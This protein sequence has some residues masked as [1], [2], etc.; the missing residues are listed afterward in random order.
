LVLIVLGLIV[1]ASTM[2]T[3]APLEIRLCGRY[4]N[5]AYD[6]T[7][8]NSGNCTA[9]PVNGN[10]DLDN[11]GEC[12][13][14]VSWFSTSDWIQFNNVSAPAGTYSLSVRTSGHQDRTPTITVNIDGTDYVVTGL[15]K[16]GY[17]NYG[18]TNYGN[19]MLSGA[20]HTVRVSTATG[21][22]NLDWVK[23]TGVSTSAPSVPTN[24]EA[25][26][27]STSSIKV[28]W[29][30]ST[31]GAAVVGYKVYQDGNEAATYTL[32]TSHQTVIGPFSPTAGSWNAVANGGFESTITNP[33]WY[34]SWSTPGAHVQSNEQKARGSY[35]NKT[36]Q[37]SPAIGWSVLHQDLSLTAGAKY[38]LSS[39]FYVISGATGDGF[40]DMSDN[41]TPAANMNVTGVWQF[42]Y[43]QFTA[44][45]SNTVRVARGQSTWTGSVYFDEVAVTP[46]G[47]FVHPFPLTRN[48]TG[49]SA[50]MKY[51]LTVR[52]Y[53]E[54][55]NYSSHSSAVNRYT[56][57]EPAA[58]PTFSDVTDVGIIV[59][60][61][62]PVNLTADSS[63]VIFNRSGSDLDKVQFL[64]ASDS[65]L[66]PNTQYAYKAKAVNGDGIETAY[67]SIASKYTLAAAP[68]EGNNVCC[69]KTSGTWYA[70]GS[71]FT[72]NNPAGFGTGSHGG[73][74]YKVSKFKYAW[75]MSQN[76]TW[77]GSEA[78]WNSGNLQ[79]SADQGEG[80]YYLHLK[81][82]NAEDAENPT[83][84]DYGP[85]NSA[86]TAVGENKKKVD[87]A[88]VFLIGKT[89]TAIFDD[90]FYIEEMDRS[91][92]IRIVASET[93]E[94]LAVGD[95]VDVEGII[96]TNTADERYVEATSITS[97]SG[98]PL[99]PVGM[100]TREVGGSDW[101]YDPNTGAGQKGVENNEGNLNNIGKLVRVTGNVTAVGSDFFYLLDGY[102]ARDYSVFSGIRVRCESE[103]TKPASGTLRLCGY[104]HQPDNEGQRP[105]VQERSGT[106]QQLG[107]THR[108]SGI[109]GL[110]N[111]MDKASPIPETTGQIY[112]KQGSL[113]LVNREEKGMRNG[114]LL[115]S[116]L[117]ITILMQATAA[118][119]V[120]VP[121]YGIY[122]VTLTASGSYTNPYLMMPAD[123]TTPGFVV[124]T[125][126]GPGG[127]QIKVD[128][129]WDGGSTWKLRIMPTVVGDW[130]YT[131]SSSDAGL[132]AKSGSFTCVAS[133]SKGYPKVD[134]ARSHHYMWSDGSPFYFAGVCTI[135]SNFDYDFGRT[136]QGGTRRVDNGEFQ[137]FMD[138]RKSQRFTYGGGCIAFQQAAVESENPGERRRRSIH[139][140]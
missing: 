134:T 26:A 85:F 50:N 67:S 119:A 20:N 135:V 74:Q 138:I 55:P 28:D 100:T 5:E 83:T 104:G 98:T 89:V 13:C 94:G 30:G 7:S 112:S 39:F 102:E 9:S 34:Y 51:A 58:T 140:L 48:V 117:A 36:S 78:D 76:H 72:F 114:Y 3:A 44:G 4:F 97:E 77:T 1:A 23:L 33:P 66:T 106:G 27:Q 47:Q 81:S 120:D 110:S 52:A 40:V 38:Y 43:K 45:A 86:E 125:F 84:L 121:R 46:A 136:A 65:G 15:P 139:E 96:K 6:N 61:S 41:W 21:F 60:T 56:R 19:I 25:V 91:S 75:T 32:P 18:V 82:Y 8:G 63:G 116:L 95:T 31:H 88:T 59:S 123:N 37:I 107:V 62:G 10:V 17:S 127:V 35:S 93:P 54:V 87:N 130:T 2:V 132:N 80:R 99:S 118:Q 49:L 92:G 57:Q 133:S 70:A 71:A 101:N 73:N 68:S 115:L 137:A 22:V 16:T 111:L 124:G 69:D 129:F 64:S 122:E 90:Q 79:L 53:D 128:G 24:V 108:R 105:S 113:S 103:W 11:G 42:G 12:G 14:V 109:S 131:T 29:I 126:T